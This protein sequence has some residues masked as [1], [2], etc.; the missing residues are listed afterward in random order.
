MSRILKDIPFPEDPNRRENWR[1]GW[2]NFK[3]LKQFPQAYIFPE[4]FKAKGNGIDDDSAALQ[5]AMDFVAAFY[6]LGAGGVPELLLTGVYKCNT[7]LIVPTRVNLV[8][9]SHTAGNLSRNGARLDFSGLGINT[10]ALTINEDV[11]IR[12]IVISG[13]GAGVSGTYGIYGGL[14]MGEMLGVNSKLISCTIEDFE[15][16]VA[17][18]RWIN[19]IAEN[20][21][22]DCVT[23][24]KIL[25]RCN[26]TTI[27]D[28]RF[29]AGD[30]AGRIALL[31]SGVPEAVDVYGNNFET[32]YFGIVLTGGNS[33]TI[34]HNRWEI[35]SKVGIDVRGTGTTSDAHLRA[36][37]HNN[38]LLDYGA[39]ASTSTRFGMLVQAGYVTI[40]DNIIQRYNAIGYAYSSAT[41]GIFKLTA[42]IVFPE[43]QAD[44][45]TKTLQITNTV[46]AGS[47][48]ITWTANAVVIAVQSGVSTVAQVLAASVVGT[49][50]ATLSSVTAGTVVTTPATAMEG[51]PG[52]DG[53]DIG[54]QYGINFGSEGILYHCLIGK[55]HLDCFQAIANINDEAT[56]RKVNSRFNRTIEYLWDLGD[57]PGNNVEH[58]FRFAIPN[59]YRS[60]YSFRT[61]CTFNFDAIKDATD[62]EVAIGEIDIGYRGPTSD[63]IAYMDD[64]ELTNPSINT[65]TY[66]TDLKWTADG[67]TFFEPSDARI[68]LIRMEPGAAVSGRILLTL[69]MDEF[70]Y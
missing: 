24:L 19:F 27:R 35:I 10:K 8:G 39:G 16:G 49:P 13:P 60:V 63:M 29:N 57:D 61:F 48:T 9:K 15:T 70:Q 69:V 43:V 1:T 44:F 33:T 21:F 4:E 38:F 64:F 54:L 55:N 65:V 37:I 42:A 58:Y 26:Y 45:N 25:D 11:T 46:T 36:N 28:N 52:M 22:D 12:G 7:G 31:I 67:T 17:L 3:K 5:K 53:G 32:V 41:G 14:V 18:S 47:E 62:T 23:A 51:L 68:Y 34:H 59:G 2:E 56:K 50:W 40:D 6:D 20:T 30:N 66:A